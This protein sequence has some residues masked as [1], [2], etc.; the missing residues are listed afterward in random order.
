MDMVCIMFMGLGETA[1]EKR[2]LLVT[3]AYSPASSMKSA[4]KP[5]SLATASTSSLS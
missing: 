4:W 5:L 2:K 3:G 1:M